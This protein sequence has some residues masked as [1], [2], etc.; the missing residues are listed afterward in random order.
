MNPLNRSV[1]NNA[2]I[3]ASNGR[4][5]NDWRRPAVGFS[6][7]QTLEQVAR[8]YATDPPATGCMMVEGNRCNDIEA[9]EAACG[10]HIAA[11]DVLEILSPNATHRRLTG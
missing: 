9:R 10:L 4:L 1:G 2:A 3:A 5:G 6:L 7:S 8:A 11:Q